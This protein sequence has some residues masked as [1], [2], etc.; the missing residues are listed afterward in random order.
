MEWLEVVEETDLIVRLR[1][2]PE[3]SSGVGE[4]GEVIYYKATDDWEQTK[5]AAGYGSNYAAHAIEAV[6]SSHKR[7]RGIPSR[8]LIGWY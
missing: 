4:Y 6:R 5:V 1:Y 3:E 7:G 2:Y 8:G